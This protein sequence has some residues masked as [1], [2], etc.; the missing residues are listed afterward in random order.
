MVGDHVLS[1]CRMRARG[2]HTR[3]DLEMTFSQVSNQ[4]DGL[5]LR[6]DSY[7]DHAGALA[8]VGLSE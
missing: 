8:A 4:R 1:T 2:G 3:I 5:A 6:V 7:T